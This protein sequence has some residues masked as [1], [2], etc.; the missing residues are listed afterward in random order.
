GV[1]SRYD[2]FVPPQVTESGF[3]TFSASAM[4]PSGVRRGFVETVDLGNPTD[5]RLIAEGGQIPEGVSDGAKYS[6][7]FY[8]YRS[9]RGDI[10][11]VARL[12]GAQTDEW[13]WL[14]G[15][16]PQPTLVARVGTLFDVSG[17]QSADLRKVLELNSFGLT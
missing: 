13:V 4:M 17:G 1:G 14:A 7:F 11:Y 15:P 5:T 10:F 3:A 8:A 2:D 6:G 9:E 16:S 12:S